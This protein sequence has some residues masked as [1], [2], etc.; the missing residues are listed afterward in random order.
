MVKGRRLPRVALDLDAN[1]SEA[2]KRYIN[3]VF[4]YYRLQPGL[5]CRIDNGIV[6]KP[7]VEVSTMP[8]WQLM[9]QFRLK[10]PSAVRY[11][12]GERQRRLAPHFAVILMPPGTSKQESFERGQQDTVITLHCE[13]GFVGKVLDDCA[14]PLPNWLQRFLL[15]EENT[16]H[17]THRLSAEMRSAANGILTADGE[18]FL[19]ELLLHAKC[20]ELLWH[21]LLSACSDR[22]EDTP[23]TGLSNPESKKIDQARELI[24]QSFPEVPALAQIASDLKLSTWKL[25]RGFKAIHGMTASEFVVELR[26]QRAR[27][28]LLEGQMRIRD[29]AIEVGY[30]YL[31]NFSKAFKRH[32]GQSPRAFR[33]S[34]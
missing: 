5:A 34:L 2:I 1:R 7:F 4:Q 13:R 18:G 20:E 31:T 22:D 28:L 24:R 11:E 6:D 33:E 9:L 17:R 8:N 10:S 14:S 15:G 3:G 21:G 29:V 19:F 12:A 25:N 16:L 27:E 26:M 32:T 23:V 30:D